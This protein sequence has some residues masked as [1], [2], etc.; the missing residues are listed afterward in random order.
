MPPEMA[1]FCH[2]YQAFFRSLLT[3]A[4]VLCNQ[5]TEK[6][7]E[8]VLHKYRQMSETEIGPNFSAVAASVFSDPC[9]P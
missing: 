7:I 8:S 5:V 3:H 9:V 6:K 2:L 4:T 1:M